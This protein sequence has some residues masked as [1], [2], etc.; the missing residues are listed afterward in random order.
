MQK[1]QDIASWI[2]LHSEEIIREIKQESIDVYDFLKREFSNSDV[3]KNYL[4]QFVYRSFYRLDNAGLTSKFKDEYFQILEEYRNSKDLDFKKVLSRLWIY[5][6]LKKNKNTFQFSFVTKMFNTI[7]DSLP[8]YDSKVVSVFSLTKPYQVDFEIKLKKHLEQL[9]QIQESYK[10]ISE[11][12]LLPKTTQRFDQ[13]FKGHG[14]SD[15]K[16]LDFIFWSAGKIKAKQ[17]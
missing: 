5:P 15:M 3:T 7:N 8:I 2:E 9:E 10:T 1:I 14:L 16:K 17:K 13:Q 4:F 12:N 6:N 11:Y